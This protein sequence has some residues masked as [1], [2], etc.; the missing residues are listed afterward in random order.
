M[1]SALKAREIGSKGLLTSKSARKRNAKWLSPSGQLGLNSS[2]A[3]LFWLPGARFMEQELQLED[4]WRDRQL[5]MSTNGE[6]KIKLLQYIVQFVFLV[7]FSVG[8]DSK[9]E[10]CTLAENQKPKWS[11]ITVTL[12]WLPPAYFHPALPS[13]R[14]ILSLPCRDIF[15]TS[16]LGTS[17]CRVWPCSSSRDSTNS[18]LRMKP[19][20]PLVWL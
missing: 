12:P 15:G 4:A 5:S 18:I 6:I 11:T 2:C 3:N 8:E 19:V 1:I 20:L 10:K 17:R 14:W 13:N 16:L 9:Q 7:R